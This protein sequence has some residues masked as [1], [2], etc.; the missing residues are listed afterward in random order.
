MQKECQIDFL[1]EAFAMG[2]SLKIEGVNL[3]YNEA[4]HAIQ[5]ELL[6]PLGAPYKQPTGEFFRLSG[7]FYPGNTC[8]HSHLARPGGHTTT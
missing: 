3:L 8:C 5:K 6:T 7:F 2:V 1:N 4:S